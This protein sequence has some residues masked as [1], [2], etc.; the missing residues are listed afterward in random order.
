MADRI[1]D[2]STFS[3]PA[4]ALELEGNALRFA[5]ATNVYGANMEFL[6]RV[7]TPP[8]P[9]GRFEQEAIQRFMR[10][11][12][13]AEHTAEEAAAEVIK[14]EMGLPTSDV[15]FS[16]QGRILGEPGRPS[17]HSFLP[18]PCV[19]NVAKNKLKAAQL[20]T[21]HTNFRS[22]AGYTGPV[23]RSGDI[24]KVSLD[25]G[26]QG[27]FSLQKAFFKTL[28]RKKDPVQEAMV[29][30]EEC[31][32]LLSLDWSSSQSGRQ[33]LGPVTAIS[34]FGHKHGSA[35]R[36]VNDKPNWQG[37]EIHYT[38]TSTAADAK[39]I[40]G[41]R[42]LSYHYL[43]DRNGTV[44][45]LIEPT[46]AA[47]HGGASSAG[48]TNHTNIGISLVSLGHDAQD[49]IQ[50]SIGNRSLPKIPYES[51]VAHSSAG[52]MKWE[53]YPSRQMDGLIGLIKELK[54][55][56][57]TI[58]RISGHEDN[59]GK[60]KTDPGPEFDWTKVTTAT[61]LPHLGGKDGSWQPTQ[62]YS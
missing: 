8:M 42:G 20:I 55:T 30:Q 36:I 6:V 16:F 37:V 28:E 26:A 25:T 38:V 21:L 9:M 43:V 18:D 3:I 5:L 61:G 47:Y 33:E 10:T 1:I 49:N 62:K 31:T 48:S 52:S 41:I 35:I 19:V 58:A 11:G 24:V 53:P 60:N 59:P 22:A 54:G 17:P 7:L 12:Q 2:P 14:R 27:P 45:K 32:S 15:P 51:W 57:P 56:Y 50:T 34:Y 40:L 46:H 23:P 13:I 44:T 39:A 4:L 29:A